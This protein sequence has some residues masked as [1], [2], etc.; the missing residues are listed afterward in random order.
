MS[1]DAL[2]ELLESVRSGELSVSKAQDRLRALA[3]ES[4]GFATIDHHRPLRCGFGE[5]IYCPGKTNEQIAEIFGRLAAGGGNVLATRATRENYD[6]VASGLPQAEYHEAARVIT[7]RRG[8]RPV[9][10]AAVGMEG[11]G[12]SCIPPLVVLS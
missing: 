12:D 7:L 2:R 1:E 6:A 11:T 4:L 5:V 3:A 8:E 10:G 9:G